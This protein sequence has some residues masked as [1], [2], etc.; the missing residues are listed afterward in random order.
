MTRC[1]LLIA[2]LLCLAARP[3]LAQLTAPPPGYVVPSAVTASP[4]RFA[5]QPFASS[6]SQF[7]LASKAT[8]VSH[9]VSDRRT[10]TEAGCAEATCASESA[11]SSCAGSSGVFTTPCLSL[12]SRSP[13]NATRRCKLLGRR[14]VQSVVL[15]KGPCSRIRFEQDARMRVAERVVRRDVA[16][17]V[18]DLHVIRPVANTLFD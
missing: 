6:P 13:R 14:T 15:R 2:M 11:T 7:R 10:C 4:D 17:R 12:L 18:A 16:N 9:G 3:S 8:T 1:T 5:E